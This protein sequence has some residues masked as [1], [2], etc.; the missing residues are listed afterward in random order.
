MDAGHH[1]GLFSFTIEARDAPGA[2]AGLLRTPH[3]T[4]RTPVFMPVGTNASV[5]S[6]SPDDLRRCSVQIV[7]ANTYHLSLRPG[8]DR[9]A[10]LGGLHHFMRWSGPILTDSG[11]FQVFSL[12][13]LRTVDEEGVTFRSQIDGSMH[14]FTPESV[15][16]TE[17]Q[18]G[19][20]IV[21]PLDQLIA[22]PATH[23]QAREAMERTTRWLERS[24]AARTRH[25]QA[26]FGI[27][28]GGTYADLRVAHAQ[29]LRRIDLPGYAIGGLSVGESK[30]E[31][32]ATLE[33]LDPELPAD[34]P[35]YLMGVGAPEDLV[36][37]VAR[38]VDMFDVVLPTRIA[39][40]GTL[41]VRTGRVNLKN[42]SHALR[43]EPIEPGCNCPTCRDFSLAYLHHLYRCEELLVYRLATL[44]N[45][46]FMTH[47]ISDIR[48]SIIEGRFAIFRDEFHRRYRPPDAEVA[49]EQRARR[50][51]RSRTGADATEED[52]DG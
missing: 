48:A 15:Q 19:A 36:E 50:R 45:I 52:G 16:E 14:R 22:L 25:D 7:L 20:D 2:R 12:G 39:R 6:L 38:G 8:A 43:D 27:V 47:L 18:I 41:L 28:Q 29:A 35:R 17:A 4:I 32:H 13:H 9:I 51:L 31:M 3:G 46:W 42:A 40:N 1:D 33:A 21:M 24:I 10:T 23:A 5:K 26:L 44:H 37:C 34:R 30:Q 49:R 11:G